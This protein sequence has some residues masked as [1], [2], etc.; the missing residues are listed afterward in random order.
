MLK[1]VLFDL[2]N[3]L[4]ENDMGIFV[5]SFLE[6]AAPRFDHLMPPEAFK[7]WMLRSVRQMIVDVDPRSSNREV[8]ARDFAMRSGY[9]WRV[10]GS[11][12]EHFYAN[13]Y[14]GLQTL[15]KP[16][17]LAR[18]VVQTALDHGI[19]AAVA[20]NPIFPLAAVEERVRWAGLGGCPFAL[21]TSYDDMHFCKPHP[22][23]YL[24][25]ADRLGVAPADCLMVGDDVAND[26]PAVE[27]GMLT[28]LV[29]DHM[30]R[31]KQ[32]FH[33]PTFSG[34]LAELHQRLLQDPA[35]IAP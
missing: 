20:T 17:P 7:R 6:A 34:T 1:A 23:Y 19:L 21:L 14:A 24:E 9:S 4:L 2:D 8:F 27:T 13:D 16:I 33:Q 5:P 11:I 26:L 22:E 29:T 35:G 25:V 31:D 30:D 12:F 32:G 18:E 28:F 15:S 10:L 3:T